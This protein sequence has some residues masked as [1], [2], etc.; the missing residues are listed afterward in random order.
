MGSL[1]GHGLNQVATLVKETLLPSDNCVVESSLACLMMRP[2]SRA[3]IGR[4]THICKPQ[5]RLIPA[6]DCRYFPLLPH[7]RNPI[8][9]R[10]SA[11]LWLW[12]LLQS[13]ICIVEKSSRFLTMCQPCGAR[14]ACR[15]RV[16]DLLVADTLPTAPLTALCDVVAPR[17]RFREPV[18]LDTSNTTIP[19][20]CDLLMDVVAP[21]VTFSRP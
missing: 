20:L 19:A 18:A 8:L 2:A 1:R 14:V 7:R 21:Q 11:N 15:A 17:S 5:S 16:R 13:G 3:S 10:V 12:P 9:G 4:L 6:H